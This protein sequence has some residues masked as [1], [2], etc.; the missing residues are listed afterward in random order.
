M[1]R[2][3]RPLGG[4]L[5]RL[6]RAQDELSGLDDEELQGQRVTFNTESRLEQ[7]LR[8]SD[9]GFKMVQASLI[10]D[11]GLRTDAEVT[12]ALAKLFAQIDGTRSVADVLE[13]TQVDELARSEVLG[14]V[15]QLIAY[16]F[17]ELRG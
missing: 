13:Q 8:W 1:V 14:V 9:G 17:L 2:S 16:G 11:C 5:D 4:E 3:T 10:R 7:V 15:R 6:L 12:P